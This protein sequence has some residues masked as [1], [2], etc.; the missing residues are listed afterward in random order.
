MPSFLN[1][2]HRA[3]LHSD[4]LFSPCTATRLIALF[5]HTFHAK[6]DGKAS[7][8]SLFRIVLFCPFAG[9]SYLTDFG[10][11]SLA[12]FSMVGTTH[13][14][15]S[16]SH[17]SA[18][19]QSFPPDYYDQGGNFSTAATSSSFPIGILGRF[20]FDGTDRSMKF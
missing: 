12:H 6:T 5:S 2:Q 11:L 9:P 13:G 18:T 8:A 3:K 10:I 1:S 15:L 19:P 4:H 17:F 14:S 16:L 20:S 7:P